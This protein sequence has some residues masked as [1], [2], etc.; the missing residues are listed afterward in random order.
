MSSTDALTGLRT[1]RFVS[2]LLSVEFLRA[3]RYGHP[4]SVVMADLDHFKDVNDRFGHPGGDAVLRGVSE[5]LLDH[6]RKTDV[7]GRYGGEEL[8][9]VMP[10]NLV[11]GAA[12]MSERWR[13]DVEAARFDVPGGRHAQVTVSVGIAE[14]ESDLDTPEDLI[15]LADDALYRAKANGRNRI[16]CS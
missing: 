13:A 5:L 2:D 15:A 12:T 7:A 9:V 14:F 3:Q 10:N 1:R 16:E 4:L 11:G 8:I 6:I